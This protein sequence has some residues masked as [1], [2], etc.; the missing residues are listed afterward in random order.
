MK[1][2]DIISEHAFLERNHKEITKIIKTLL[3]TK[4]SKDQALI[5]LSN[6]VDLRGLYDIIH[7]EENMADVRP[8]VIE[9]IAINF[10]LIHGHIL[11]M[12]AKGDK[13]ATGVFSTVGG[14]LGGNDES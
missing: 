6:N 9:F 4:L 2:Y 10:P 8:I 7:N 13:I 3:G 12:K 11:G 5:I 14:I 1:I